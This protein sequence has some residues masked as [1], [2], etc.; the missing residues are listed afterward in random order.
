MERVN[1]LVSQEFE[2]I[3]LIYGEG[4]D[5]K[6][7]LDKVD[8]IFEEVETVEQKCHI[9][10]FKFQSFDSIHYSEK[11]L[12]RKVSSPFSF[13]LNSCEFSVDELPSFDEFTENY[14]D[15]AVKRLA[16]HKSMQ[17]LSILP[18]L[19]GTPGIGRPSAYQTYHFYEKPDPSSTGNDPQTFHF[20]DKPDPSSTCHD[21]FC[22]PLFK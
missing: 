16:R 8:L 17:P 9:D 20:F 10:F 22:P 19:E 18:L 11:Y 12:S 2:N 6:K 14:K 5:F 3:A 7:Y 15:R 13:D 1:E 21:P 4:H